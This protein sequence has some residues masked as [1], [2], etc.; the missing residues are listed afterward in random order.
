MKSLS[1]RNFGNKKENV[2]NFKWI[3]SKELLNRP[4]VAT[5]KAYGEAIAEMG[6][7]FS[8][9]IV[10]E[11]DI[12][13][14][15]YSCLFAEKYPKRF[16]NVGVAEQNEMMVAAGIATTGKVPFVSTYSVFA[17]MRAC[18]QVRTFICYPRLNVKIAVSH[19]GVTPGTDGPTHQATEDM[20]IMRTLPN[21]TILMPADYYSTKKLLESAYFHKG[22]VYIRLTRDQVPM[23]YSEDEDF[24]IGKAKILKEGSDILIIAIGD[25]LNQA[26]IACE[27]LED[28]DISAALIDCHTL[29]PL[30][31]KTILKMAKNCKAVIT[32]E[33]HQIQNGLGS[34]VC[35]LLSEYYPIVVKRIGLKDTFARSGEYSELLKLYEM[36]K[37]SIYKEAVGL[38]KC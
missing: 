21:I 28:E 19:G 33:D 24:Q 18:E 37:N 29:K 17:S 11:A 32:V 2:G 6:G 30:D 25:L 4:L 20:G 26:I 8:D 31:G 36:D 16:I 23:I 34:A 35:E 12:S 7:K 5:R 1:D 38:L 27:M 22:P 9:I 3:N 14:S 10:L 13:K 15:T